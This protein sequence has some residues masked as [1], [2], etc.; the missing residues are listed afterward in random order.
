MPR[1]WESEPEGAAARREGR[2]FRASAERIAFR[3][4]ARDELRSRGFNTDLFPQ[5]GTPEGPLV[6]GQQADEIQPEAE[7]KG[8]GGGILGKIASP[9]IGAVDDVSSAVFRGKVREPWDVLRPVKQLMDLSYREVG[10]PLGEKYA[11]IGA[12]G[13]LLGKSG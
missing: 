6:T 5:L 12:G 9:V 10:R 11:D 8:G 7:S 13:G 1:W 3:R 2:A 4:Q